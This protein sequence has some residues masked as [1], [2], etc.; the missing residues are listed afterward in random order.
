[1]DAA[2]THSLTPSLR[3]PRRSPDQHP[4]T[5]SH[6]LNHDR[7]AGCLPQLTSAVPTYHSVM[8][9]TH[10]ACPGHII[11]NI[12][13]FFIIAIVVPIVVGITVAA[14]AANAVFITVTP[15][16]IQLQ[17]ESKIIIF[18]FIYWKEIIARIII[19]D[20]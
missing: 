19:K 8:K 1:M 13:V 11:T 18:F 3:A 2:H 9:V 15:K 6:G 12:T 7:L 4:P 20:R 14:A 16:R 10:S 5:R 17:I